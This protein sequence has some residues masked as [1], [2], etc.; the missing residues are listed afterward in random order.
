[1]LR[2]A[3]QRFVSLCN[4][5]ATASMKSSGWVSRH[6]VP[7]MFTTLTRRLANPADSHLKE[8]LLPSPVGTLLLASQD[9]PRITDDAVRRTMILRILRYVSFHPWGSMRADG[10]RRRKCLSNV[11]HKLWHSHPNT[12]GVTKFNSRAGV[13][14][15]P[16]YVQPSGEIVS[17]EEARPHHDQ[18][19]F[20]WLASRMPP[21][22]Y[23]SSRPATQADTLTINVT[24]TLLDSTPSTPAS[25]LYDCR[26]VVRFNLAKAPPDLA[27]QLENGGKVLIAPHTKWYWPQVWL[28]RKEREDA[29]VLASLDTLCPQDWIQI[30]WMRTLN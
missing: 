17:V 12:T 27:R 22:R 10:Y 5:S 7:C 14:W 19:N 15:W 18:S 9:L 30:E 3:G 25:V 13:L 23:A 29:V 21:F 4:I 26:F 28:H 1:M 6:S 2:Q 11:I 20:G 8:V 16:M 24:R